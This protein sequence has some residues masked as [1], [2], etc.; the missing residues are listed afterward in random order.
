MGGINC[1]MN[2]PKIHKK[3]QDELVKTKIENIYTHLHGH[4]RLHA[5]E[6]LLTTLEEKSKYETLIKE[7]IEEEKNKLI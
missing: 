3:N 2:K 1:K 4:Q 5:L 7:C 6:T